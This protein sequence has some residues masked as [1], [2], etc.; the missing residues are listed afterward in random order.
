ML[1]TDLQVLWLETR[2]KD[3]QSAGHCQL[4]GK[5]GGVGVSGLVDGPPCLDL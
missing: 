1:N 4:Q 5:A 2:T 3:M